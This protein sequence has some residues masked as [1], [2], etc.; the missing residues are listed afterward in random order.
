MKKLFLA[1]CLA[2]LLCACG[3][4]AKDLYDTAQLEER[5]YN[6]EHARQLYGEILQKYP[7]SPYAAQ[8]RERLAELEN[9]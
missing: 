9:P 1:G 6:A 4:R 7:D 8:A 2:L 5:Q 3:D